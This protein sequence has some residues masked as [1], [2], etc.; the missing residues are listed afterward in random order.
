MVALPPERRITGD[1]LP[2]P[3]P[4]LLSWS[5]LGGVK[6][7]GLDHPGLPGPRTHESLTQFINQVVRALHCGWLFHHSS[8]GEPL[9]CLAFCGPAQIQPQT[10]RGQWTMLLLTSHQS[11]I[12]LGSWCIQQCLC[13]DGSSTYTD[14]SFQSGSY[15]RALRVL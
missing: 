9:A 11:T 4:R 1:N 12:L 8:F 15:P 13:A 14:G 10:L 7:P 5:T 3:C 6:F 2:V